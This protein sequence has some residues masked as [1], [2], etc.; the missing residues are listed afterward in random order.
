MLRC[1]GW[2]ETVRPSIA[3]SV[4]VAPTPRGR[5]L[6]LAAIVDAS[7][8]SRILA[9]MAT[10]IEVA[11]RDNGLNSVHNAQFLN[12]KVRGEG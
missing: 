6:R 11:M 7:G 4:A 5:V 10:R 1:I 9:E 3:E 12:D 8:L 2:M